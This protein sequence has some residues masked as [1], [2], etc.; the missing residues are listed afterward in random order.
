MLQQ[1]TA[2]DYVLATGET[3]T[4]RDFCELSFKEVG[5]DIEWQGNGI[6]EK[7]IDSSNGN[8][9]VAIDPNYFRPTEVDLLVG[10][11]SKA[12]KELGWRPSIDFKNLIKEMISSDLELFKKDIHL[13]KGGFNTLSQEE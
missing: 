7:G 3:N 11:A 4:V 10:D 1:E 5:I 13:K 2:E 8:I 12:E 6:E 9:L